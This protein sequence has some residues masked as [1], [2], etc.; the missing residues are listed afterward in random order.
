M[1]QNA[2]PTFVHGTNSATVNPVR[3]GWHQ[4]L[5]FPRQGAIEIELLPLG[6]NADEPCPATTMGRSVPVRPEH[7]NA[8]KRRKSILRTAKAGWHH[9]RATVRPEE[10]GVQI[11]ATWESAVLATPPEA[12]STV[13]N[14]QHPTAEWWGWVDPPTSGI[15]GYR[16]QA[17]RDL[18]HHFLIDQSGSRI[19]AAVHELR[20]EP[21][22]E[23]A[24]LN[25]EHEKLLIALA[26]QPDTLSHDDWETLQEVGRRTLKALG[27]ET[28]EYHAA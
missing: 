13:R 24:Q 16:R 26:R 15:L 8:R 9:V 22:P 3:P 25:R 17:A 1:T 28:T 2:A 14:G 5:C 18:A 7:V 12:R 4:L 23:L 27:G 19:A 11:T 20:G 21:Y 6:A 10:S